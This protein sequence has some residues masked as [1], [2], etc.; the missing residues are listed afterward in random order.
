LV[1][2]PIS[3]GSGSDEAASI[4]HATTGAGGCSENICVAYLLRTTTTGRSH[5]PLKAI[6]KG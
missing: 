6:T 4:P 2:G 3:T 5:C 1:V